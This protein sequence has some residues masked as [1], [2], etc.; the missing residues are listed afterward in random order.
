[1]VRGSERCIGATTSGCLAFSDWSDV[2]LVNPVTDA[3]E[4][5]VIA[6]HN[7]LN[8]DRVL[9]SGGGG[10]S[11][12]SFDMYGIS[13]WRRRR[14][15]GRDEWSKLPVHPAH[16]NQVFNIILAVNCN[17]C[18]YVFPRNW[19]V[20]TVDSSAQPPL[21]TEKLPVASMDLVRKGGHLIGLDGEVLFVHRV[22]ACKD[23]ELVFCG[24]GE[25]QNV[26]VGF[27]VYKLDM[28][29]QRWSKVERLADDRALFVSPQSSFAV[30]A[31]ETAGCRSN[32][33]YFVGES[34]RCSTCQADS[35]STWGMYS[36][37]DREDLFKQAFGGLR[38]KCT[39]ARW[40]LPTVN[41]AQSNG[42]P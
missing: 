40:F 2:V 11:F 23:I 38:R 14:A 17:G 22:I 21:L 29:A 30:R 10:D 34:L 13:L 33:I 41:E 26:V 42:S 7:M 9:V 39:A 8:L 4:S 37:E 3:L 18:V 31:S 32:C 27:E 12:F 28:K 16:P 25:E 35:G 24:H 20:S 5:V 6:G 15:E 36:I 19:D 1:M